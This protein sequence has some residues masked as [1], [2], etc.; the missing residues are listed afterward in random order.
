MRTATTIEPIAHRRMWIGESWHDA[1]PVYSMSDALPGIAIS[2]RSAITSPFTTVILGPD[3]VSNV[4]ATG[5]IL[6]E[7]PATARA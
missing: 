5:D 7:L 3:E 4:T 6:I 2:G 1:A